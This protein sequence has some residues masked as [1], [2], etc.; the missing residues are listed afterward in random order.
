[1]EKPKTKHFMKTLDEFLEFLDP[2]IMIREGITA[3]RFTYK[4][5]RDFYTRLFTINEL[6][7]EKQK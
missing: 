6:K 2:E 1:M 5:G 7:K 3:V 4:Y